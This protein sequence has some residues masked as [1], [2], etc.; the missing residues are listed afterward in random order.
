MKRLVIV[1]LFT[2]LISGCDLG[3]R[4]NL[5]DLTLHSPVL[6]DSWATQKVKPGQVWKVFLAGEDQD[7]DMR[8][9]VSAIA[10]RNRQVLNYE[11]TFLR[12]NNRK[13][14]SGYLY[15]STPASFSLNGERFV[16]SFF[17]RDASGRKSNPVS[18]WI[19]FVQEETGYE[20]PEKWRSAAN[21]RLGGIFGDYLN[22][23]VRRLKFPRR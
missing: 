20:L 17:I 1:L 6:L 10:P 22:N 4:E 3:V 15:A 8:L 11:S 7:G 2:S 13:A 16:V 18:F 23:Y 9:I 12:G 21:N 19:D 5:K 14:F